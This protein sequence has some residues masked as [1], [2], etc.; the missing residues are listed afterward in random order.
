M[1]ALF[2]GEADIDHFIPYSRSPDD[3]AGNEVVAHRHCNRT[4]GKRTFGVFGRLHF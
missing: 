3:S 4:K 1:R 2:S